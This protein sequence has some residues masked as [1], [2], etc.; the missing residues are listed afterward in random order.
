MKKLYV[1]NLLRIILALLIFLFHL[2]INYGFG[3]Q[4]LEGLNI[5]IG[6][7]NILMVGF[8]ILS[9]F[10]LYYNYNSRIWDWRAI[11][12][13]YMKRIVAVYPPYLMILLY[14]FLAKISLFDTWQKN[15]VVIPVQLMGV[16]VLFSEITGSVGNSGIWFVSVMILLYL[17]FP[18]ICIIVDKISLRY[19]VCL[20]G[21][22]YILDIYITV[23]QAYFNTYVYANPAFRFLEFLIGMLIAKIYF[24]HRRSKPSKYVVVKIL[25]VMAFYYFGVIFFYDKIFFNKVLFNYSPTYFN[26]LSIPVLGILIY[27]L[28]VCE[29]EILNKISKYRFIKYCSDLTYSFYIVQTITFVEVARLINSTIGFERLTSWQLFGITFGYN[30]LL[31]V[32]VHEI[33]EKPIKKILRSK[34]KNANKSILL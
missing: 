11:K 8:F 16:Q 10:V 33:V 7:G 27:L 25:L 3:F 5:F 9:G 21:F 14:V 18:G 12:Q 17:V 13:F 19:A 6:M 22:A 26:F 1:L 29:N 4:G 30:I 20:A 23:F 2:R 32:A 34:F 24:E 15:I 31:C 28:S